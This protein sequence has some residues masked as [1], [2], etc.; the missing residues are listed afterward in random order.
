MK[1]KI[2]FNVYND[3]D[4]QIT[5]FVAF[6]K[7]SD[8]EHFVQDISDEIDLKISEIDDLYAQEM[9]IPV[10]TKYSGKFK[11]ILEKSMKFA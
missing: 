10:F 7:R 2:L 3:Q 11:T 8:A 9:Y 5:D 4:H 6:T 1:S